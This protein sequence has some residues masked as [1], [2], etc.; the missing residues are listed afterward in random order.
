MN[1]HDTNTRLLFGDH[2]HIFFSQNLCYVYIPNWIS[3]Q[4]SQLYSWSSLVVTAEWRRYDLRNKMLFNIA[5][6]V[7]LDI[8]SASTEESSGWRS[9]N[10]ESGMMN[11]YWRAWGEY[12]WT[13]AA[14]HDQMAGIKPP[15]CALHTLALD[16]DSNYW[17]WIFMP[18][19][20]WRITL[21][22][23]LVGRRAATFDISDSPSV[24]DLIES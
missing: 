16:N 4:I 7:G 21:V 12:L 13:N 8:K 6:I 5:R 17:L 15:A 24:D 19:K 18:M 23:V 22:D 3:T 1:A 10:R 9:T 20:T 11:C 2:M 14:Y